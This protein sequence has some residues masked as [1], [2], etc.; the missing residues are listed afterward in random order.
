MKTKGPTLVCIHSPEALPCRKQS[1]SRRGRGL[2][3]TPE[4]VV[5]AAICALGLSIAGGYFL[6]RHCLPR[7][8]AAWWERIDTPRGVH[9][10]TRRRNLGMAIMAVVSMA[11]FL[12]VNYME[13]LRAPA[14][15]VYYWMVVL[16][17]VL[18]ICVLALADVWQ[19]LLVHHQWRR[20]Q[21]TDSLERYLLAHK[22]STLSAPREGTSE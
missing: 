14:Q 19:T 11:T 9:R 8:P 10:R 5:S 20:R 17:L 22:R 7:G 1:V 13:P 12:G 16:L 2:S 18:W 4:F 6:L 3:T 15:F 21:S